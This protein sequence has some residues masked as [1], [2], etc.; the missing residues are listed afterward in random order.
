M[1]RP[2]S[3]PGHRLLQPPVELG[4]ARWPAAGAVQDLGPDM[5]QAEPQPLAGG[6]A[7][8]GHQVVQARQGQRH[9][10]L[11]DQPVVAAEGLPGVPGAADP[12]P[13][14][15]VVEAGDHLDPQVD[16]ALQ[17]VD[18]PQQL[19]VRPMGAAGAHGQAVGDP[20]QAAGH[21]HLGLQHQRAV[22]VAAA[23][24]HRR[25]GRGDRAPAAPFAVQQ[26]AEVA[27]VV[28]AGQAQP[29]HRAV[30]RHQR[31]GMAVAQ[32][33]VVPDRPVP[34]GGTARDSVEAGPG[35][36]RGCRHRSSG[37]P[38]PAE[39]PH[40]QPARLDRGTLEPAPE[41]RRCLARPQ[42]V[43]GSF[44]SKAARHRRAVSRC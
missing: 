41:G 37:R 1:G 25:V 34:A 39:P 16:R 7:H 21:G 38:F 24:A 15:P 29:V 13:H 9:V 11:D 17:A 6:H 23:G 5:A 4:R 22:Q 30:R 28:K 18:D 42:H 3:P 26:P 12:R 31:T 8:L 33:R 43:Q 10:A 36:H 44:R 20:H 27:A 40:G 2:A 35:R 32:E 19:P 14:P